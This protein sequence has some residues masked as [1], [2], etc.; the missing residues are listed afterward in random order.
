MNVQRLDSA[1]FQ[2][3]IYPRAPDAL[4]YKGNDIVW[5]A[6]KHAGLILN[7]KPQQNE[8]ADDFLEL[9][10]TKSFG[11]STSGLGGRKSIGMHSAICGNLCPLLFAA[12]KPS[13]MKGC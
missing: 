5:S 3:I 8:Q 12:D 13:N 10:S 1:D 11:T 4:E 6:W 9:I 7:Y 2:P